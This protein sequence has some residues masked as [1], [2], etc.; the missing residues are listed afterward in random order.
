V[1]VIEQLIVVELNTRERY[2]MMNA[3]HIEATAMQ[4]LIR[5]EKALALQ[6]NLRGKPFYASSLAIFRSYRR[7]GPIE[8]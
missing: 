4:E 1:T 2:S 7:T 6:R 5:T 8:M 3:T